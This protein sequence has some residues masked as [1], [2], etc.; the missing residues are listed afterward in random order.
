MRS[1]RVGFKGAVLRGVAAG[2][3]WRVGAGARTGRAVGNWSGAESWRGRGAGPWRGP[4][5]CRGSVAAEAWHAGAAR[6]WPGGS[7]R[8]LGR[9]AR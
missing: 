4:L 1:A 8:A 7:G 9:V 2:G 5:G 6:G 3:S